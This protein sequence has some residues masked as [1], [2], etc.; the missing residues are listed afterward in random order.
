MAD[1][2]EIARQ[3][4][5][6]GQYLALATAS[7]DGVPWISPLHYTVTPDL[8]F[9]FI[10]STTS[11]HADNIRHNGRASWTVFWGEKRP[12]ETDGVMF[13]GSARELLGD[14][15]LKYGNILYDHRFQDPRQRE[16]HPVDIARFEATGR[17]FYVLVPD[18]AYKLDK[19]DIYGVSRIQIHLPALV[20]CGIV[21]L[22]RHPNPPFGL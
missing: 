1:P 19:E 12:E 11:R 18:E 20:E 22:A 8:T 6:E 13:G 3:V 14:E 15:A 7:A 10:S 9:I 21:Q 17:A 2:L 16:R 4:V 5:S